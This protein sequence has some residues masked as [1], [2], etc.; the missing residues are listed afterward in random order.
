MATSVTFT[1]DFGDGS[2]TQSESGRSSRNVFPNRAE[3][4]IQIV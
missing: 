3:D 4:C 1:W 2:G